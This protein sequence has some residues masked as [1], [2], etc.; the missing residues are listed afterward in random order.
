MRIAK[1]TGLRP[2]GKMKYMIE[3][4]GVMHE[5]TQCMIVCKIAIF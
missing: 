2:G 1:G 3:G 4:F 5:R